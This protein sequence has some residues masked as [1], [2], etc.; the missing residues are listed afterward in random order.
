MAIVKAQIVLSSLRLVVITETSERYI[1]QAENHSPTDCRVENLFGEIISPA[2]KIIKIKSIGSHVVPAKSFLLE[3]AASRMA[4][5]AARI[6]KTGAKYS[7]TKRISE[8]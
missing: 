8:I 5:T 3:N 1:R 2:H 4:E 6:E 7:G